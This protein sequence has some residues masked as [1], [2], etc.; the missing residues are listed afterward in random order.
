MKKK[1][2]IAVVLVMVMVISGIHISTFP[3][4]ADDSKKYIV[5]FKTETGKDKVVKD[6]V[7]GKKIANNFRTQ[8]ALSM[9][10]TIKEVQELQASADI[11]Y[12]E[13]DATVEILS[14][15][16]P[17]KDN[18]KIKTKNQNKKKGNDTQ[19]IPWGI[20]YIGADQTYKKYDGKQI[21]VAVFDTGISKHEDIAI[22][23]GTS[24]V[25][26]TSTYA[27]D[28]GHG[29]H[30][31]G[32][33]AAVNNKL[34]V[35]GVAPSVDLYAVKVLTQNGGGNYSNI[36]AALEWAIDNKIDVIN[37][38]LG[39][40]VDSKAFHDA[41]KAAVNSGIVIVAAAGNR[42]VG[43]DT[44]TYPAKYPEV[45]SVG[46]I[47]ENFKVA[48]FSSRGSELD[49]VAPGTAVISTTN[50]GEYVAM[51]GTSMAAP[52]VT[53]ALAVLKSKNKKSSPADLTKALYDSATPLGVS[54]SYGHGLVN[55]AKAAGVI[56][57]PVKDVPVDDGD[58]PANDDNKGNGE[59]PLPGDGTFDIRA[60]DVQLNDYKEKLSSYSQIAYECGEIELSKEIN[61]R[62]EE[63]FTQDTQLH[64]LPEDFQN[65]PKDLGAA[66]DIDAQINAYFTSK[67]DAF[68]TLEQEYL[69]VIQL[70]TDKMPSE[71]YPEPDSELKQ[72]NTNDLSEYN[73]L[74]E[75]VKEIVLPEYHLPQIPQ[76]TELESVA[77]PS[78]N[79]FEYR[80][81]DQGSEVATESWESANTPDTINLDILANSLSIYNQLAA[82]SG[83][84]PQAVMPAPIGILNEA[85]RNPELDALSAENALS[86][87]E[88]P[89][90]TITSTTATSLTFTVVYPTSGKWGNVV[91]L[92][93]FNNGTTL[94]SGTSYVNTAVKPYDGNYYKANGTYT[95]SGLT[96]GG[97]YVVMAM[98]STDNY[99]YGGANAINR[100]KQLPYSATESLV[101]ASGTYVTTK[102]ESADKSLATTANFTT[103]MNRLD[104]SYVAL[105]SLTGYTPYDGRKIVLQSSRE[106]FNAYSVDGTNYWFLTWAYA[107][108]PAMFSQ[109][110]MR[111]QMKRLSSNDWSDMA[112][113]E[114]SHDFDK[115]AWL[116]DSEALADFKEYYVVDSLGATVYRP[117][118]NKYYAGSAFYNFFKTDQMYS[119]TKSF[120]N[121]FYHS[122]GMTALLI[123]IQKTIGW[124]PF[125]DTFRYFGSL[126]SIPSTSIDRFN[127]F[128]T[129]L[130]EYSG[131]DVLTKLSS[132]DKLI[133]GNYFYGTVGY[134]VP[135]SATTIYLNT[136]IDVNAATFKLF[137]FTPA[138]TGTYSIIT[139]P[140]AGNA[141]SALC[142]TY[143]ELYTDSTLLNRIDY[144]DDGAGNFYSKITRELTG[145][146]PYYIKLRHYN[147]TSQVYARIQVTV[148][149]L[150]LNLNTPV[151][152]DL[153]AGQYAVYSITPATTGTYDIFTGPYAG[154]GASNDTYLE[155]YSDSTLTTR[156]AYND[157]ADGKLFSRI[158]Q[159][160]TA[161]ITYYVKLRHY[162][163]ASAV[164]ARLSYGRSIS[165]ITLNSYVDI[166]LA[167]GDYAVYKFTPAASGRYR[168]STEWYGGSSST[169]YHDTYLEL[170]SDAALTN[171]ITYNDDGA[172]NLF[173]LITWTMTANT[174]YY[175]KF[176]G[177][178]NN[179]VEGRL[180]VA[181][182]EM[183]NNTGMLAW[184]TD[185]TE[186]T[187]WYGAIDPKYTVVNTGM[188]I[189]GTDGDAVRSIGDG[190]VSQ[191]ISDS[192]HGNM[193]EI[194][195]KY[196]G[197]LMQA[198]YSHLKSKPVFT[199]G[200]RVNKGT[201]IG[202]MGSSGTVQG[203]SLV[204][205]EVLKESAGK[206]VKTDPIL[207][208]DTEISYGD[209]LSRQMAAS[210][211][212][213]S[214]NSFAY[215][216]D[217]IIA[218][219]EAST[220]WFW[221]DPDFRYNWNWDLEEGEVYLRKGVLALA[222][223]IDKTVTNGNLESKNILTFNNYSG[224]ATVDFNGRSHYYSV[225][226]GNARMVNE[227]LSVSFLQLWRDMLGANG[228]SQY[229]W[230]IRQAVSKGGT[231]Y[232]LSVARLV[233]QS[234]I[235]R[236]GWGAQDFYEYWDLDTDKTDIVIHHTANNNSVA[237]I[238]KTHI[239]ENGFDGIGYHFII[240]DNGL[241]YEGRPLEVKGAHVEG[242]NTG[243]IGIALIGNF[244][245]S[246]L[247]HQNP[248]KP[249]LESM[250]YLVD[251]LRH[252]YGANIIKGHRDY[253]GLMP[254]TTTVCPG[255]SLYKYID[256]YWP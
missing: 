119:Y 16:K 34:G 175:I 159:T 85:T 253:N 81:D 105:Q 197:Q 123:D 228:D 92:L 1:K 90:L 59:T 78:E 255:D 99:S 97:M 155:L 56:A 83:L 118:T 130:K 94:C 132:N 145:G 194:D 15:G 212:T 189:Q 124:Q 190:Y 121:G 70:Y 80:F 60:T 53:G 199:I 61:N 112:I 20:E 152:L 65:T 104:S 28:N 54:N 30:V 227:R 57:G 134:V 7:K 239:S 213:N 24:F 109:P 84:E 217:L 62:L 126:S 192:T 254:G 5:T 242:L 160:L 206:M 23:G 22:K 241:I 114:L 251:T 10:L 98:W 73:I 9:Q 91:A 157:D 89:S 49:L 147:N 128:M 214:S 196:N 161:G 6:K 8:A 176:K 27:D 113:H 220:A 218:S 79:I 182:D 122:R 108:N 43:A 44:M 174:A 74:T 138:S 164:H 120:Q 76:E 21:K 183:I 243:K 143:L 52:H 208:F 229:Q 156:I 188:N 63:L 133:I 250:R 219:E 244:N 129:K 173:S 25:E 127:L 170:Y 40:T 162:S 226:R 17:D 158:T 169:N 72:E 96:P 233:G 230:Y 178:G 149:I 11:A 172:G 249:Q 211:H 150:T 146:T 2:L 240:A 185:S 224:E 69:D 215:S 29:T 71:E 179:A 95:I 47:D 246:I 100:W 222:R 153:P 48:S 41:I 238:E 117:D 216:D 203:G 67:S 140:Y 195:Y 36:I 77:V 137:K 167:Q 177:Y 110:F 101:E 116:F 166:K 87:Q 19:E 201:I 39:G 55:I 252:L 111:S 148:P 66:A 75:P 235:T 136:P 231:Q 103:W 186:V 141:S 68:K 198:R 142:D 223:E 256:Q 135:E 204:V 144:N 131:Y 154:T 237:K 33:I 18:S 82:E 115:S 93:D 205:L 37:M 207:F 14:V 42:G 245:P 26:Y 3:V 193:I 248:T 102:V 210:I 200:Q 163:S 4:R 32:T 13:E 191:I 202:Y 180:R 125:K 38:S 35:L 31:A 51:S 232:Q 107:G 64:I 225:S 165:T 221:E 12:I 139:S 234:I 50:D 46:A 171:K 236:Q 187:M 58:V 209:Y 88:T 45:I 168:I 247:N 151:D 184:P 86:A 181:A 106:N